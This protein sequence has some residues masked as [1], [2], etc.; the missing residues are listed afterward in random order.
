L[1]S[2]G[3]VRSLRSLVRPPLNG[4]IVGRTAMTRFKELERFET[5]IETG[6]HAELEW[7]IGY[8]EARIAISPSARHGRAWQ[9]RLAKART[10]LEGLADFSRR[11]D[12][13]HR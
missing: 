11:S 6:V 9:Q 4:S 8:C 10:R 2:D 12:S 1:Q 3:R 7:A 5:A 13:E